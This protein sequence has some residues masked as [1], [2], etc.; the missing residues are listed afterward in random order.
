MQRVCVNRGVII[1]VSVNIVL[2]SKESDVPHCTH[3]W[4]QVS[5][6]CEGLQKAGKNRHE[7]SGDDCNVNVTCNWFPVYFS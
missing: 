3:S 7:F 4:I 1:A 2:G 6:Q 5:P